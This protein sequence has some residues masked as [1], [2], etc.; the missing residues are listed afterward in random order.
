M[1]QAGKS[2]S[3]PGSYRKVSLTL[4]SENLLR[5]PNLQYERKCGLF[6]DGKATGARSWPLTSD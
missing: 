1:L 6:P 3:I 5:S 2:G 4:L